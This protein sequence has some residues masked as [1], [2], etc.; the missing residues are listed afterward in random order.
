[1]Y[2][3]K[4]TLCLMKSSSGAVSVLPLAVG[5]EAGEVEA[6]PFMSEELTVCSIAKLGLCPFSSEIFSTLIF[7]VSS[8][9]TEE[10]RLGLPTGKIQVGTR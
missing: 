2:G 6:T 9:H 4:L 8:E 1:M 10:K 7:L 5:L 3:P